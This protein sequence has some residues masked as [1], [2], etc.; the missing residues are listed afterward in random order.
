[1]TEPTSPPPI[2]TTKMAKD[3][4]ENEKRAFLRQ[5]RKLDAAPKPPLVEPTTRTARDMSE[6]ERAEWLAN[7]KRRLQQ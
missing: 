4:N 3:M 7:H 2:D 6:Q 1:M 5:C